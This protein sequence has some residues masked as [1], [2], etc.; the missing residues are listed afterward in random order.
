MRTLIAVAVILLVLTC[1]SLE[2][3]TWHVPSECPTIQAGIDSAASGDTVLLADETFTGDGNRDVDFLGKAITLSSQSGTPDL[4]VIECEGSWPDTHRAFYFHS[5]EGAS[6]ILTSVTITGGYAAIGAG[7]LCRGNSSPTISDCIISGNSALMGGGGIQCFVHCDPVISDCMISGNSAMEGGGVCCA[8][9]CAPVVTDCDISYN[10]AHRGGGLYSNSS[11]PVATGCTFVGNTAFEGAGLE[12]DGGFE[13]SYPW[14]SDCVF[15]SNTATENGGGVRFGNSSPLIDGCA[16]A[17][18]SGGSKGGGMY[19]WSCNPTIDAC[20][21]FGNSATQGG[22]GIYCRNNSSLDVRNSIIGFGEG[23]GAVGCQPGSVAPLVCCDVFANVGGDWV[24]CL[25]DQGD[26][27][28]NMNL[29]PLFCDRVNGDFTLHTTSP[30][31]PGNND[32]G[33]LIGAYEEGCSGSAAWPSS[34]GRIK[35]LFR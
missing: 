29:D 35:S 20:T 16:F 10:D 9:Y 3:E 12:A 18:N 34:W 21:L 17:N 33:E 30:C 14:L 2:A 13:D 23:G 6:S 24:G 26:T 15:K 32:C 22:G 4:C 8:D 25:L 31:L 1:Q 19:F 7:I 27:N 28:G 11:T 5:G